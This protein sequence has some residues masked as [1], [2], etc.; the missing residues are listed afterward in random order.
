M[1]QSRHKKIPELPR[2]AID[3]VGGGLMPVSS[4]GVTYAIPIDEIVAS[5]SC[6]EALNNKVDRSG[7]TMTGAL[8]INTVNSSPLSLTV[9]G[10]P[11]LEFGVSDNDE[12]ARLRAPLLVGSIPS[13]YERDNPLNRPMTRFMLRDDYSPENQYPQHG[14]NK[15]C[16]Y[17][18][19]LHPGRVTH[20]YK[21][22]NHNIDAD[23]V[24]QVKS[25]RFVFCSSGVM[26]TPSL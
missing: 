23:I 2:A 6:E 9:H 8:S 4:N 26:N 17:H 16:L 3:N 25:A 13:D 7:D 5:G 11:L 19:C 15:G 21:E 1:N 10:N 22:W 18:F 12:S 24:F 20:E 14:D